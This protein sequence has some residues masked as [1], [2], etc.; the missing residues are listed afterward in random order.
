MQEDGTTVLDGDEAS[1]AVFRVSDWGYGGF[2]FMDV[3]T[4][5]YLTTDTDGNLKCE[6][7][8]IWGWFTREL[9]FMENKKFKTEKSYGTPSEIGVAMRKGASIYDKIYTEEGEAKIN[10][11]LGKLSL[12]VIKDA[13]AEAESAAKEAD[14]CVVVLGNHSLIGARECIDRETLDFPPRWAELLKNTAEAN[15]NTVLTLIA[16]YP[17]I[18]T[19]QEKL[20]RAVIFTS[21]GA[22]EVGTAVGEALA[23]IYNPAGRLSQTWY[24]SSSDLPDINDYDIVKNKMTY[25]FCEKPVLHEFGYGL[26]YGK[27]E[28]SGL[29][30]REENGG[31][32]VE[33]D[34]ANTGRFDGDEVAQIYFSYGDGVNI[35]GYRPVKKLAG[36]DRVPLKAGE[37]KRVSIAIPRREFEFYSTEKGAFD[38]APGLYKIMVGASSKDIRCEG[39]INI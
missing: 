23:G 30:L 15:A 10:G 9:F 39:E 11:L 21:H 13:I 26:S 36:F 17:Y 18:I 1:R 27:F 8:N 6:S 24:A 19:E 29:S 37:S 34:L 2:G 12:K 28:Y 5:K 33:F 35:P 20:A 14:A 38:F 32:T 4:K 25:I 7:D 16:G 31:V 3:K 22:Q